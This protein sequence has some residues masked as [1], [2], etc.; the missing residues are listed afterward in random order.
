MTREALPQTA[1][2]ATASSGPLCGRAVVTG[3]RVTHLS[4]SEPVKPARTDHSRVVLTAL[5][6]VLLLCGSCNRAPVEE[7]ESE[8]VVSV[9]TEAATVGDIRGVIHATAIVNPAPGADLVVVAPETARISELPKA[10]GDSVRRGD[11]LVR[12]E[13]PSMAAEVQRQQ[14]EVARAQAALNNAKAAQARATELF[15]R[16]VA[17]RKE[18]EEANRAAVDAEATVSQAQASLSAAE[19]VAARTIVRAAFDGV[20]VKRQHNPGD[21]VEPSA[22][23]AVLRVIDPRRL[24]VIAS[25]PLADVAR[26]A[27]GAPAHLEK[28]PGDTREVALRVLSRPAA[29][30]AGT[31]TVPVRLGFSAPS[32]L[33]AG[34]PVQVEIEAEEHRNVVLVPAVAVAREGDE[35]AVFVA[36]EGKAERRAVTLGLNDGAHVEIAS[37]IKAGEKVIVDGQAGLPDGAAISVSNDAE[38][39]EPGAP[40]EKVESK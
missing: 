27:V 15:Q 19:T 29:V 9:K 16:G 26:I 18:V 6:A 7:V 35:T 17:A 38:G 22:S 20:V 5:C 4:A 24:E 1:S 3:R 2:R 13:I 39:A 8:T 28:A 10:P 36:A 25:V 31:G 40:P 30:E 33:P 11:V 21:L 12:F 32:N 23:D 34:L 14:A 37:G